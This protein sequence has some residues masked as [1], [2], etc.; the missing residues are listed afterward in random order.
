MRI[1]LIF[2]LFGCTEYVVNPVER[3]PKKVN[4]RIDSI[5]RGGVIYPNRCGTPPHKHG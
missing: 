5:N 4:I 3:K 2:I 1:L